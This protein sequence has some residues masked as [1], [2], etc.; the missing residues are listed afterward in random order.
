MFIF[1]YFRF[2]IHSKLNRKLPP[3][4]TAKETSTKRDPIYPP[5]FFIYKMRVARRDV[6]QDRFIVQPRHQRLDRVG[7]GGDGHFHLGR[8][9]FSSSNC[10]R[11]DSAS[12]RH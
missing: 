7:L 10:W 9:S 6:R 5:A 4:A 2:S 1:F 11:N 8:A 12:E 3:A